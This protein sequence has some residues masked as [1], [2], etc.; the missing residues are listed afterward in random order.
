LLAGSNN[1]RAVVGLQ[2]GNMLRPKEFKAAKNAVPVDVPRIRYEAVTRR[3]R[4]GNS[5]PVADAGPPQV[6]IPAGTITLDGSGSYDPDGDPITYQWVQQAGPVVTL[7]APTSAKTTFTAV[8]GASYVFQLIVTDSFGAKGTARTTVSTSTAQPVQIVFFTASPASISSGQPSTLSW[9]VLNADTVTLSGIG[10]VQAT[11][12]TQVAPTT[13]TTYTLSAKNSTSQDTATAVV[14]VNAVAPKLL[15]CYANPTSISAGGSSTL[16]WATNN[17]TNVTIQPGI[18]S[19]ALSGSTSVSPSQTTTYTVTATGAGG[20]TSDTCNIAV[21]I[22]SGGGGNLPIITRFTAVP[23]TINSGQSSTLMWVVQNASTVNITTLGTVSLSGS[24]DVSPT[25]TTTYT[26]TATNSSGNATATATVTVNSG[27]GGAVSITSFTAN[28]PSSTSP[29]SKV[30][31]TCT[32]NGATTLTVAGVLFNGSTV[33]YPVFPT[34]TTTYTCTAANQAGQT[35][36]ATVT[37]PV[38]SGGT[39]TG[40][41][42]PTVIVAGGLSQTTIYRQ[43][44]LDATASSSPNLPLTFQWTPAS[45]TPIAISGANTPTPTIQLGNQTGEYDL[46]LTVTD[47]KGNSTTVT[48]RIYLLATHVQ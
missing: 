32:A 41:P 8:S 42:G 10:Q 18:G 39:G 45:G 6:N 27:G 19:V 11:S 40:G 48:V 12:S 7:S 44:T 29:G 46:D 14:S 2:F 16:N 5:P 3:V 1:G 15:Y 38:S 31:L 22:S 26:L 20:T 36:S 34:A 9:R 23:P 25:T 47:S 35:A 17:A 21:A 37:V 28:P 30:T 24:Q 33:S 4:T 13:T 43:L